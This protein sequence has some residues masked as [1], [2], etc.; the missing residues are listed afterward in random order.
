[1]TVRN[2]AGANCYWKDEMDTAANIPALTCFC[3]AIVSFWLWCRLTSAEYENSKKK[4]RLG[5]LF[6][7]V[8]SEVGRNDPHFT[9]SCWSKARVAGRVAS[10]R[11]PRFCDERPWSPQRGRCLFGARDFCGLALAR[12]DRIPQFSYSTLNAL[13]GGIGVNSMVRPGAN[14]A[15]RKGW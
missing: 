4:M 15:V 7:S 1:M 3:M 14:R 2:V 5:L 6:L 13:L 12:L 9:A 11:R 10:P 8:D